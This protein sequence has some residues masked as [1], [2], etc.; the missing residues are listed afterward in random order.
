MQVGSLTMGVFPLNRH[1]PYHSPAIGHGIVYRAGAKPYR[2]IGSP[3]VKPGGGSAPSNLGM[4]PPH[5][6]TQP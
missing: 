4:L 6:H 1:E 5:L 3:R 2:D